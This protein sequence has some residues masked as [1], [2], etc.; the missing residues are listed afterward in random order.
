MKISHT[1]FASATFEMAHKFQ[2]ISKKFEIFTT[3]TYGIFA[4]TM[5]I[6]AQNFTF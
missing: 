5:K 4:S 1:H 2:K 6:S 3:S